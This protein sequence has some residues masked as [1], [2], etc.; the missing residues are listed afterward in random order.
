[1]DFKQLR[2]FITV[3][4]TGSVS[5]AAVLLNLVQPAV[6]RQLKM[7]ETDLGVTLF[8]RGRKGMQLTASGQTLAEHARR[9]LS[10]IERAREDVKPTRAGLHGTVTVGVL[11]STADLLA[12][13]LVGAVADRH[14]GILL[15]ISMGYAGHL[16]QWVEQGEVDVGLLYE[17]HRLA[18]DR[19]QPLV[20]EALWV[21]G[22]PTTALDFDAPISLHDVAR[23]PLILPNAPHGLRTLVDHASASTGIRLN[24]VA[25]TNAM[26]VQKALV[27]GGLGI[28]I[29]PASAVAEDVAR[30]ALVAAPLTEPVL[31]RRIVIATPPHRLPSPTVQAVKTVLEECMRLAVQR[32]DWP[33]ARWL[34]M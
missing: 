15:R 11:P 14:P 30:R 29:L 3:V 1:M 22:L 9:V 19:T 18:E 26:G 23:H 24:V 7:L 20:E 8:E 13:A 28:T 16:R 10:E 5:R 21:V 34:G 33:A 6:S 27:I 17:P 12:S 2:A 31:T 32:G 25:E 4:D